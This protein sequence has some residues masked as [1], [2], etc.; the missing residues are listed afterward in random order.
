MQELCI[1]TFA[2]GLSNQENRADD[3][4]LPTKNAYRKLAFFRIVKREKYIYEGRN[5]A[6]MLV[7]GNGAEAFNHVLRHRIQKELAC[8]S[9]LYTVCPCWSFVLFLNIA[10]KVGF[11]PSLLWRLTF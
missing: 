7:A 9:N 5:L 6:E 2:Q 3:Y 10:R 1:S 4:D 8:K 11:V